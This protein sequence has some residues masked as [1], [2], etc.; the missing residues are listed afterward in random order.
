MGEKPEETAATGVHGGS[1][2]EELEREVLAEVRNSG[3]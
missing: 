1:D 3:T 2:N